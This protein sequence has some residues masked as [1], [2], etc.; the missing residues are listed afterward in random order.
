M[1]PIAADFYHINLSGVCCCAAVFSMGNVLFQRKFRTEVVMFLCQVERVKSYNQII[2]L[3][4]LP[5]DVVGNFVFIQ[6]SEHWY[7]KV[8]KNSN[9]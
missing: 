6:K 5:E 7:Q 8:T 3:V 4:K 1:I 2:S 9:Q